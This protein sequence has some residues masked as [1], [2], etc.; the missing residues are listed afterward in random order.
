[1]RRAVDP[2]ALLV[3]SPELCAGAAL[4]RMEFM[5]ASMRRAHV[6][7]AVLYEC[8]SHTDCSTPAR[9][10]HV[11]KRL[12]WVRYSVLCECRSHTCLA[13]AFLRVSHIPFY[14]SRM[15]TSTCLACAF[16]VSRMCPSS[17]LPCSLLRVSPILTRDY[18]SHACALHCPRLIFIHPAAP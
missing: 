10:S 12:I 11:T 2:R 4:R 14:V 7:Q 1:V 13:C 18:V 8:R 5:Q 6:R 17:S 3:P 9:V 16:F 15:F